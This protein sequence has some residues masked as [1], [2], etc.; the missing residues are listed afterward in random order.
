M[1]RGTGLQ[2][3][4][5]AAVANTLELWQSAFHTQAMRCVSEMAAVVDT[6]NVSHFAH[7]FDDWRK[8]D[9]KATA[10]VQHHI[11]ELSKINDFLTRFLDDATG[12][13]GL[14]QFKECLG[15]ISTMSCAGQA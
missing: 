2:S 6:A 4:L 11:K 1:R 15:R 5:K 14:P 3:E 10:Q 9:L 7:R 8:A 12:P 13:E